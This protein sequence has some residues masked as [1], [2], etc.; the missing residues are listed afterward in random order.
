L[1]TQG[2]KTLLVTIDPSLRL[3]Q[4]LG[5]QELAT[6][7]VQK[8]VGGANGHFAGLNFE[9]SALLLS[10]SA[11]MQRLG[12]ES[13]TLDEIKNP[14]IE[15]LT[16]PSGGMNEIM[17]IVEVQ[18]HLNTGDY[19]TIVLDTPPGK[20]FID[21]LESSRKIQAFFDRSF[22]EI[23]NYLGK[24]FEKNSERVSG[25]KSLIS[26]LVSTGVR[27]LLSYLEKVTG[28]DF[29]DT[30]VNAIIV[31]YKNR[32]QFLSALKFQE[33]LKK[34]E[35]SNWFLV[36]SIEHGKINEADDLQQRADRL[37][38]GDNHLALN[39]CLEEYLN[40]WHSDIPALENFRLSMLN[41]E[42]NIKTSVQK[43]FDH[44][45]YFSEIIG[46]N[47]DQHVIQLVKQWS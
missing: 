43:R 34:I 14:I 4:V 44:T 37:M 1:A 45:L 36:A 42:R 31:L 35:F 39:K 23:F 8:V 7:V 30:F 2:R 6:G 5:L 25:P 26:K 21:F 32:D 46:P 17:A 29:V 47:V 20:H 15:I 28:P 16:R 3:K 24:S 40:Q 18:H 41:R 10:P 22:I 38:H 12:R 33:Q 27:K 19:E 13:G 11:T 9:L